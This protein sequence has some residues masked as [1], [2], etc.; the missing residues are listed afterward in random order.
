MERFL[1]ASCLPLT[2]GSGTVIPARPIIKREWKGQ[3]GQMMA[4]HT[5]A[6]QFLSWVVVA[7][8]SSA[9]Y[10]VDIPATNENGETALIINIQL[11]PGTEELFEPAILKAVKCT[12][13]ELGN[14]I[15][16]INKVYN[17]QRQYV[18]YE[19]WRTPNQYM[20]HL[21]RPYAKALE[22][23]M[24]VTL[25]RPLEQDMHFVGDFAPAPRTDPGMTEPSQLEECK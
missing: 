18:L 19:V 13:L 23:I 6:V 2:C 1:G 4:V 17:T 7:L 21:Q 20:A 10:A 14:I 8:T 5:R 25:E 12:R 24:A 16:S 9:A 11:K 15:F 3:R 22:E